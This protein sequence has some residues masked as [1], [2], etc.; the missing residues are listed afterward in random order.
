MSGSW[1]TGAGTNHIDF[2]GGSIGAAGT[3]AHSIAVLWQSSAAGSTNAGLLNLLNGSTQVRQLIYDSGAL[4]GSG[5]FSSGFNGSVANNNSQWYISGISKA[6]GS[7]TYRCH[8]GSWDGTG[9]VLQHG[10]AAAAASRGGGSAIN[11]IQVGNGEDVGQ[12]LI[13]VVAIWTTVLADGGFDALNSL[14]LSSWVAQSPG[15][16][17]TLNN[18]N[19][20]TGATDVVGTASFT[21]LTG[22]VGTGADPGGF[23]FALGG[24][25]GGPPAKLPLHVLRALLANKALLSD[26]GAQVSAVNA[27]A[28]DADATADGETAS[29]AATVTPADADA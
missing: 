20:S 16:L 29:I 15:A 8:H 25:D 6:A 19:G 10:V 17:I 9:A 7:N 21:G 22:T 12:G 2:N 14:N 5:D 1:A 11:V 27:P 23:S 3:G 26:P 13:A 28:A 4:F 18:W 24:G